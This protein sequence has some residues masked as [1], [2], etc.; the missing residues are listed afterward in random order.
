MPLSRF[1]LK[2]RARASR[3]YS[4]EERSS[5][6][7]TSD[8]RY[9]PRSSRLDSALQTRID[10]RNIF[11]SERARDLGQHS[12]TGVRRVGAGIDAPRKHHRRLRV[13]YLSLRPRNVKRARTFLSARTGP[14][15]RGREKARGGGI[16]MRETAGFLFIGGQADRLRE[17]LRR[18]VVR[19]SL[20]GRRTK[21]LYRAI[22]GSRFRA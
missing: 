12:E 20:D 16:S 13:F 21:C 3:D 14:T 6:S 22:K 10:T 11:G 17:N 5:L 15:N 7:D 18:L 1:P 8:L 4:R 9:I 19:S 2:F